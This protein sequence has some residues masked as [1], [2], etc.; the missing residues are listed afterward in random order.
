MDCSTPGLPVHHQL[1]EFTH[2]HVHWVGDVIQPAHPLSSPSLLAFNL[3]QHQGLFKWI[4]S[5]HQVAKV[6]EFQLQHQSFQHPGL[7]SYRMD[8]LD[9]LAVQ[10]T[11]KSLLQH[12]FHYNLFKFKTLWFLRWILQ[13]MVN[14]ALCLIHP[15]ISFSTPQ[16]KRVFEDLPYFPK[17][18]HCPLMTSKLLP[19]Q[20]SPSHPHSHPLTPSP[21]L[22]VRQPQWPSLPSSH[23]I[24]LF[25]IVLDWISSQ[26]SLW[27]RFWCMC[28]IERRL[29]RR[30]W[31]RGKLKRKWE[32]HTRTA[33][34]TGD[35]AQPADPTAPP[36]ARPASCTTL[37]I[38]HLLTRLRG[39]TWSHA[40]CS[41][42]SSQQSQL[43]NRH[44]GPGR[45]SRRSVTG[46]AKPTLGTCLSYFFC[47]K[48]PPFRSSCR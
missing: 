41:S 20:L 32:G 40:F 33:V 37:S 28:F 34:S 11:L 17:A 36:T 4:S 8:W 31:E 9:L 25:H 26:E 44:L 2:I 46:F 30:N 24:S 42:C 14:K 43:K 7:I 45:E 6:L 18:S 22:S 15:H 12:F 48:H 39:R 10:G 29:P 13:L 1:P 5:L 21:L 47:Q 23:D 35:S 19:N 38:S 16:L 27:W 3:S